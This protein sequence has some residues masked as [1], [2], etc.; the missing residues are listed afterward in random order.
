MPRVVLYVLA[1]ALVVS[2]GHAVVRAHRYH[3]LRAHRDGVDWFG[4]DLHGVDLRDMGLRGAVLC[5]SN[6]RGADLRGADLSDA[7]LG[8]ADLSMAKLDGAMLDRAT[9]TADTRW[10]SGFDPVACGAARMCVITP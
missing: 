2:V 4:Q 6:L 9:Y 1:V 7:H 5:N 8:G 10:P 3:P